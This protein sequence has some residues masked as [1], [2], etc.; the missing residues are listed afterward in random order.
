MTVSLHDIERKGTPVA[1]LKADPKVRSLFEGAHVRPVHGYL[2]VQLDAL[3]EEMASEDE[4][5]ASGQP[6][7]RPNWP[8]QPQPSYGCHDAAT[9]KIVAP[10][11]VK[12][13]A[14][15]T[16]STPAPRVYPIPMSAPR[17][18]CK[19]CGRDV[20]WIVTQSGARVPCEPDG[21]TCGI[22]HR[23]AP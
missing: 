11:V 18:A 16:L 10:L 23:C 22:R 17:E 7:R 13:I 12:H 2:L 5:I 3:P 1:K 4:R 19:T 15:A 14:G 6:L 21:P 9:A 20:I 8:V